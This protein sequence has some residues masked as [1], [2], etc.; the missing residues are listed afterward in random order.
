MSY[1]PW[2][3]KELDKTEHTHTQ[4]GY[5]DSRQFDQRHTASKWLSLDSNTRNL[6]L[7]SEVS[8]LTC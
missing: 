6:A 4:T 3:S 8:V 1:S 7:K 2:G 5:R